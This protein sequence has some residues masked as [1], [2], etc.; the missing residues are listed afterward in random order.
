M[1]IYMRICIQLL[2]TCT[3]PQ[4]S[5]LAHIASPARPRLEYQVPTI[6][7]VSVKTFSLADSSGAL[8]LSFF[9]INT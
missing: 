5:G 9:A 4:V 2:E 1:H 6:I 8:F 3:K 7:R